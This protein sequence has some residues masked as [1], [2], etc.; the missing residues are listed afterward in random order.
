M[1]QSVLGDEDG[2]RDQT[3]DEA[4]ATGRGTELGVNSQC[5][6]SDMAHLCF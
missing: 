6:G 1:K 2:E 4:G 5:G 3:A